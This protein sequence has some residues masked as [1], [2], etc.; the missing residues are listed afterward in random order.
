MS[1]LISA[2]R[3]THDPGL[4][5][6]LFAFQSFKFLC[7]FVHLFKALHI[8]YLEKIELSFFNNKGK[9]IP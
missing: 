5:V 3:K 1:P 4:V 9:N 6:V 8:K 2:I 7:A